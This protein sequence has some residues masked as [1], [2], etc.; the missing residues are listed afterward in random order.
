MK[1]KITYTIYKVE[2][3]Q[4][5]PAVNPDGYNEYKFDS[6]YLVLYYKNN[7]NDSFTYYGF[8]T[9]QQLKEKLGEKQYSKFCQGKREFTLNK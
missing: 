8:I 4:L 6:G 9:P 1:K 3:A 2:H 5:K 7:K